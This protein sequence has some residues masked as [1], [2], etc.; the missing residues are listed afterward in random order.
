[1]KEPYIEGVAT[2]DGPESCA[3]AREGVG[4]ALTGVRMGRVIEPRNQHSGVPTLLS[5]AEGKTNDAENARHRATLRGRRPLARAESSCART[6]RSASR[7]RRMAPW[8]ASGR[9]EAVRR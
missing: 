7:S 3:G 8:A 6:G 9:P 1:M 4:E 5:E 2:H